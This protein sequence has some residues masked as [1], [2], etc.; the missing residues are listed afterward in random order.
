[1][2][3]QT[4]KLTRRQK[5]VLSKKHVDSMKYRL[6]KEN[7]DEFTVVNEKGELKTFFY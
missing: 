1:M 7:S 4:K 3:K 2:S 6:V 5:E